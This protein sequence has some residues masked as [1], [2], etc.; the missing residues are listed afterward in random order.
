[1][2]CPKINREKKLAYLKDLCIYIYT[3]K[4]KEKFQKATKKKEINSWAREIR[5]GRRF[6]ELETSGL[7]VDE[8]RWNPPPIRRINGL[9]GG[10]GFLAPGDRAHTLSKNEQKKKKKDD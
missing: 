8:P 3:L 5:D 6:D 1:M 2:I 4:G 7:G 10:E 9:D